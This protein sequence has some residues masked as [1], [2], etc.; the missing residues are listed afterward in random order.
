MAVAGVYG[1]PILSDLLGLGV[2]LTSHVSQH[3][4][5]ESQLSKQQLADADVSVFAK[6]LWLSSVGGKASDNLGIELRRARWLLG[7]SFRS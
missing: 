3:G 5:L 2:A 4:A 1:S 6:H 7:C